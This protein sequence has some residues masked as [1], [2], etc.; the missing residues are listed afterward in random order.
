MPHKKLTADYTDVARAAE[1]LRGIAVETPL[2]NSPVIDDMAGA[3]IWAKAECLQHKN[4]FKF[5][6]AYNRLSAM[7]A[8]ECA[9]GVVA[10]SSGNHAQGVSNAAMRLGIDAIIVM[11]TDA[12]QVKVAG[13]LADGA[14]I[15]YYDRQTESREAIAQEISQREGRVLVPSYD[16]IHVIAGQGTVGVEIAQS[17]KGFDALVTCI[18]GG[19]L[20]AGIS[21]AMGQLS[22]RT[23]IYGAEPTNYNDHQQSLEAGKRVGLIETPPSLC[24]AIL[25]PKPGELTWPIN[26]QSLRGVFDITDDEA[27][28]AM[29]VAKREWGVQL[30]PGGAVALAAAIHGKLPREYGRVCVVLSGGNADADIIAR[31]DAMLD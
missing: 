15:L 20:C 7:N 25:T 23:H 9:R 13:V 30:E 3:E 24:D 28:F 26:S 6:G 14:T 16:D 5:R 8:A 18:G 31:A 1:V 21:L 17:G 11:P 29:A 12:P 27:L 10:F 22:P 4:A 2:L 19:G